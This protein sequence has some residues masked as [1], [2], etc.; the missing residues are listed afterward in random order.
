MEKE[1]YY[2]QVTSLL[3]DVFTP[4]DAYQ[5]IRALYPTSFLLESS[6]YKSKE[7][8]FSY[9]VFE[10]IANLK[11]FR[12]YYQ[13]VKHKTIKKYHW[14]RGVGLQEIL[15]NFLNSFEVEAENQEDFIL[16]GIFGYM[17]YDAIPLFEK[18]TLKQDNRFPLVNY[19]FF[20]NLLIF[21][22]FHNQIYWVEHLKE[23]QTSQSQWI[24]KILEQKRKQFFPF[25]VIEK[26]LSN[27]SDEQFLQAIHEVQHHCK[28]GNVFQLVLS[29]QFYQRYQGDD[30][31][32]YRALRS[33]NPSPYLFYFDFGNFRLMGS[34]PEAQIRIKNGLASSFPI[35]GTY[36]IYDDNLTEL[37]QKLLADK[38]ENAEHNMLVDLA[39]NDLSK[40]AYKTKVE[41]LKTIEVYSHVIHLVSKIQAELRNLQDSIAVFLDTLPAGTLSGAPKYKAMQIINE[42]ELSPRGLYGGAVGYIGFNG[43]I[44]HA[45]CIR[46]FVA[47]QNTLQYQAGCGIVYLSQPR[48]ELHEVY[49]KISALRKSIQIAHQ[50]GN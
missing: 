40:H 15:Q 38:K 34:S 49:H 6:D 13:I 10:P 44:N 46:S 48:N 21:D 11:V 41:K 47:Y 50:Y 24:L 43:N 33:I 4:V 12:D 3:G 28:I 23:K 29:R 16:S 22:H 7:N 17:A 19:Y 18:I 31:Q 37:S 9:I 1:K 20:K 27:F 25:Q 35:A 5:K 26:E 30:F 14:N 2:I 45:I 32:V 8:S 42:L 39:R 36:P